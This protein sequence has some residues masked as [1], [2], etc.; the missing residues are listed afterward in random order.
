MS[1]INDVVAA[2]CLWKGVNEN[3]RFFLDQAADH[4]DI[5][6]KYCRMKCYE[7]STKTVTAKNICKF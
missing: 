6:R 2:L 4:Q 5:I 1:F 7:D 3:S